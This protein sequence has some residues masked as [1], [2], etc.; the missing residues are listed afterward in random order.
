MKSCWYRVTVNTP[1]FLEEIITYKLREFGS[2]GIEIKSLKNETLEIISYHR[3]PVVKNG[4]ESRL[5]ESAS[6]AFPDREFT[7]TVEAEE[8]KPRDWLKIQADAFGITRITEDIIVL[9]PWE[10]EK[11]KPA[12]RNKTK[13]VINP[14]A[15]FGTGEHPTTRQ[16]II[17]LR[18]Y[19][20]K[21]DK[22]L[23]IGAGSGIL[24]IAALKFG[25]REAYAVEI[26]DDAVKNGIEN[27]GLNGFESR[28][29]W[30]HG[31]MKTFRCRKKFDIIAANIFT[32]VIMREAEE[33]KKYA[34]K[35]CRVIFSGITTESAPVFIKAISRRGYRLIDTFPEGEWQTFIMELI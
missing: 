31:S 3:S 7:I 22:M 34:A 15:G 29:H 25:A 24:S 18:D 21:G 8:H 12:D 20:R 23:D 32:Y 5:V 27:T 4:V 1:V 13:I 14:G 30:H 9:P 28:I 26:D 2:E 33:I 19:L 17:A 10:K 6:I 11:L 35:S 16:C